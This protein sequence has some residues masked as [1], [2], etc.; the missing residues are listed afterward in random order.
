MDISIRFQ[1]LSEV[2]Q[3]N[4]IIFK[5]EDSNKKLDY[6]GRKSLRKIQGKV[7][8]ESLLNKQLSI[9]RTNYTSA[10]KRQKE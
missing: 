6:K 2:N 3:I 9:S 1:I 4:I 5:K 10:Q 7:H 8:T